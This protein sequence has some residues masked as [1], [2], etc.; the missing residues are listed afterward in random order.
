MNIVKAVYK[1]SVVEKSKLLFD[2]V[3]E[4][5]FVGRSNVGKSSLINRLVNVKRLAKTSSTPG[6]TKMVNYFDINDRFRFVDLP[7]YGYAK[8]GHKQLEVWAGLMGEYL[9][10]SPSLVTVFAL[11]DIRHEPSALDK[12]MIK[13]LIFHQ[14]PFIVLATKCDKLSKTRV[15]AQIKVLA[16]GLGVREDFIIPTSSSDGLG[17]EKIL[18]YIENQLNLREENEDDNN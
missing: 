8:V 3:P 18:D 1:T 12:E 16:A 11:V 10:G 14:L 5:A 17:R 4:F 7:G 15:N 2:G 6:L 9:I 13:F